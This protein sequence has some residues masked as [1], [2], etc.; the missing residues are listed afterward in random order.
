M[1]P[2]EITKFENIPKFI[3]LKD[4]AIVRI[5]KIWYKITRDDCI[6][7]KLKKLTNQEFVEIVA[8]EI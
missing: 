1:T 6:V 3:Y 7:S 8:K 5:G 2:T 4:V